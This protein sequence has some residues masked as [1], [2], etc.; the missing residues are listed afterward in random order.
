MGAIPESLSG[1]GSRVSTAFRERAMQRAG[2][3]PAAQLQGDLLHA[4]DDI[5]SNM[6]TLLRQLDQAQEDA[7][8]GDGAES[9]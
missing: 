7:V 6:S 9:S 2:S 5:T 1:I 8:N 4:A 3:L